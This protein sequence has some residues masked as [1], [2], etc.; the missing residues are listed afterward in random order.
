MGSKVVFL[1]F[2]LLEWKK[3]LLGNKLA[4]GIVQV[5]S[6]CTWLEGECVTALG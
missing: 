1:V 4:K 6:A 5:L 2:V 3:K